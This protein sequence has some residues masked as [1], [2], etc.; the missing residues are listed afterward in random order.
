MIRRDYLLRMIAEFLELLNRLEALKKGRL[1][2]EVGLLVDEEF[3]RMIGAGADAVAQLSD[4]ELLAR[5]I[6]GEPTQIVRDKT[7]ILTALLKEAGDAAAAQHD[8]ERARLFYL[9]AL[10]LLLDVLAEGGPFDCPDFVPKVDMLT[11]ALG[12]APLPVETLARL[13][14]HYERSGEFAKAEDALFAIVE[15]DPQRPGLLEFGTAFYE[16]LRSQPDAALAFGNLPR[17]EIE[18][19]VADL[20]VKTKNHG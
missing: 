12:D 3:K 20:R 7:L 13:M 10:H 5:V 18:A 14:Q 17:A 9:K 15:A 19:G 1:W 4:T 8:A 6:Q 16:R 11:A 2:K